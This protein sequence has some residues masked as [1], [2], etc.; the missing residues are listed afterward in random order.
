MALSNA[1]STNSP[2]FMTIMVD[3]LVRYPTKLRIFHAGACHL[4]TDGPLEELHAFAARIGLR[5]EWFQNHPLAAHYDL[6]EGKRWQA[7]AT[8]A[9]FVPAREQA[10]ARRAKRG[11]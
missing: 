1:S 4:T 3:E 7:L 9:V 5:R 6:T 10:K 11:A 8:G 2:R